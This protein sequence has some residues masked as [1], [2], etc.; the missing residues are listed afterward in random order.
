MNRSTRPTWGSSAPLLTLFLLAAACCAGSA[1]ARAG[2]I[3][4]GVGHDVA[5]ADGVVYVSSEHPPEGIDAVLG[6]PA[7]GY[8]FHPSYAM[9][10]CDVDPEEALVILDGEVLGEA[11]DYDGFPAY[12]YIRPGRHELQFKADGLQTLVLSGAF[13]SGAFIRVDRELGAGGEPMMVALGEPVEVS[14]EEQPLYQPPVLPPDDGPAGPPA[15]QGA[16]LPEDQ[17][18][19]DGF[20][21]LQVSPADAAV[22]IDD[23]FFGSGDEISR[24]H[25]FIRLPPGEHSIQVIRP[26]Y[27][28]RTLP[29]SMVPGEKQNLDVWLE[30]EVSPED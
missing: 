18:G 22:Y 25:G 30:R 10:D 11:D 29:V 6:Y 14:G 15:P 20:L 13:L 28:A 7:W 27:Q 3:T 16:A 12:L 2:V 1:G 5:M 24:L 19:R 4:V 21:K 23:R 8:R 17:A 9:V 26:G